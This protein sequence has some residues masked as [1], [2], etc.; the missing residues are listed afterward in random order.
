MR[1]GKKTW[2]L[3]LDK[4]PAVYAERERVENEVRSRTGKD[5]HFMKDE[6]LTEF[7]GRCNK[8]DLS[9]HYDEEQEVECMGICS[10]YNWT[11]VPRFTPPEDA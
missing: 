10:T 4:L 6:T 8:D 1:A 7:R 11:C 2:K 9:A 3:L 5:I